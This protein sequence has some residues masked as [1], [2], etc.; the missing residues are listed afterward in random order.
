MAPSGRRA[1]QIAGSDPRPDLILLDVMMPEIDG[2][3]VLLF[4]L[5]AR[6]ASRMFESQEGLRERLE[7]QARLANIADSAPG[8]MYSFR[9]EADSSWC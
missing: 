8:A 4:L 2:Y 6:F 1:L 9:L 5:L 7:L 3:E